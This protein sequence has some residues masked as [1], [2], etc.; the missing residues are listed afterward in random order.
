M[1]TRSQWKL[2]MATKFGA[3][4]LISAQKEDV[5]ECIRDITNGLGSDV[6]IDSGRFFQIG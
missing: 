2:D 4:H 6:V 5:T 3:T 1:I